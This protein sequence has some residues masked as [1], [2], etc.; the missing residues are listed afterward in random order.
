M[1]GGLRSG[2]E[3]AFDQP[4]GPTATRGQAAVARRFGT[5]TQGG[6]CRKYGV[7]SKERCR[8]LA[9]IA[10]EAVNSSTFREKIFSRTP[11]TSY[12]RGGLPSP[13]RSSDQETPG[14]HACCA[15]PS[16]APGRCGH[17]PRRG[18]RAGFPPFLEQAQMVRTLVGPCLPLAQDRIPAVGR[19]ALFLFPDLGVAEIVEFTVSVDDQALGHIL[20]PRHA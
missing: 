4:E 7:N 20:Q 1:C 10:F 18:P 15:A 9:L 2:S 6:N 11:S 16:R 12:G 8:P 13:P 5:H 3:G 14:S 17:L 19:A